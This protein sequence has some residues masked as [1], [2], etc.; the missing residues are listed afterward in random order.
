MD[1][2][3]SRKSSND[4]PLTRKKY[5]PPTIRSYGNVR[6]ITQALQSGT[7]SDHIGIGGKTLP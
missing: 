5:Q 1:N 6:E 3:K 2:E 7:V 4:R